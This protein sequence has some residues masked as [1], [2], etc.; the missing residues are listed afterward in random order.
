MTDK[1]GNVLD[2]NFM[3]TSQV[4]NSGAIIVFTY[5]GEGK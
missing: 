3:P 1:G 4:E 5:A 2:R